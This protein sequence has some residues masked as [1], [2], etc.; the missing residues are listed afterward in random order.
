MLY[1]YITR[2]KYAESNIV[3]KKYADARTFYRMRLFLVMYNKN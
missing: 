2:V 1:I 3:N